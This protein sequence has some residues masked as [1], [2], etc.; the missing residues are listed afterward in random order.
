MFERDL[1]VAVIAF[2]LGVSLFYAAVIGEGWCYRLKFA[3]IIDNRGGRTAARG[4][5]GF[6]GSLLI[7]I[8]IQTFIS[9]TNSSDGQGNTFLRSIS[10]TGSATN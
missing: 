3:E 1:A 8:G 5:I 10:Q 4:T 6:I 9:A 2:A 7:L